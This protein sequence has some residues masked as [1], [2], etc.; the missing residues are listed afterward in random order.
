MGIHAIHRAVS[1]LGLEQLP[2]PAEDHPELQAYRVLRAE[3]IA[4]SVFSLNIIKI[5]L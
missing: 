1:R 5:Q 3:G 4:I 2:D